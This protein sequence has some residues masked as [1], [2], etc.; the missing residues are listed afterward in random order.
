MLTLP[1]GTSHHASGPW[2]QWEIESHRSINT[3]EA[4]AVVLAWDRWRHLISQW[5]ELL[6]ESDNVTTV[7]YLGRF[8]GPLRHLAEIVEPR[9]YNVGFRGVTEVTVNTANSADTGR[10]SRKSPSTAAVASLWEPSNVA[11][12]FCHVTS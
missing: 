12:Y 10:R 4:R 5:P 1:D 2:F 8:G 7:A 9:S 3:L 6:V 11:R